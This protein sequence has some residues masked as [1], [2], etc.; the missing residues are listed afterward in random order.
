MSLIPG[1]AS[2]QQVHELPVVCGPLDTNLELIASYNEKPFLA[3][4]DDLQEQFGA[5]NLN[6]VLFVNRQKG[7][8][9]VT[10]LSKDQKRICIV[11]SGTEVNLPNSQ[12]RY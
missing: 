10:L 8:Y 4:K 9:T 1:L 6:M 12:V 5:S 11:S 2:S 3:G 7:T